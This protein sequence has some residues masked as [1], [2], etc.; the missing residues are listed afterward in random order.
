MPRITRDNETEL[1]PANGSR[2]FALPGDND[3]NI[4]GFSAPRAVIVD[5]AARVSDTVYAALRPMLAASPDGQLKTGVRVDFPRKLARKAHSDPG[6]V[7]RPVKFLL[8]Q[9]DLRNVSAKSRRTS[10]RYA[11]ASAGQS[12]RP[13]VAPPLYLAVGAFPEGHI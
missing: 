11:T 8:P 5:E 1:V 4:C 7:A 6:F 3:A 12:L 10:V 2:L 9:I 13:T